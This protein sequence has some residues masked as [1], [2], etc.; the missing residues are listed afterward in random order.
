MIMNRSLSRSPP[1]TA[2]TQTSVLGRDVT[3]ISQSCGKSATPVP[4]SRDPCRNLSMVFDEGTPHP[5]PTALLGR[6]SREEDATTTEE[7]WTLPT[8]KRRTE[9]FNPDIT[10]GDDLLSLS[11]CCRAVPF[12]ESRWEGEESADVSPI[13]YLSATP[14]KCGCDGNGLSP[15]LHQLL[16]DLRLVSLDIPIQEPSPVLLLD[17]EEEFIAAADF[18]V[19][20]PFI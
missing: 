9:G 20:L 8:Q 2:A 15:P 18:P 17:G 14:M 4:Y 3:N 16:R 12:A 11:Q 5:R 1:P 7:E 13:P 6:R 10:R 19:L